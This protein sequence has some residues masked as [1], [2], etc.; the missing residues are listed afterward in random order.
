MRSNWG[1]AVT[2]GAPPGNVDSTSTYWL[3]YLPKELSLPTGPSTVMSAVAPGTFNAL[4]IPLR[5]GRDFREGDTA[6]A[7]RTAIINESFYGAM[8]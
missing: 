5:R 8:A 1:V 7:P 2:Q 4:G 3:D 6:G